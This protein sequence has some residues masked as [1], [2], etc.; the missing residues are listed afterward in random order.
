[1]QTQRE[2]QQAN[3]LSNLT[4]QRQ[5]LASVNYRRAIIEELERLPRNLMAYKTREHLKRIQK[6][7]LVEVLELEKELCLQREVQL[8]TEIN[9]LTRQLL[10]IIDE[11]HSFIGELK[12]RLLTNV[13]AYKTR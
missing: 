11:R 12:K 10:D 1:M 5:L 2:A 7:V 3:E 4:R 9:N 6:T 13:M 8:A